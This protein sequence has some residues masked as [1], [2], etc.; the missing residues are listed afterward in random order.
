MSLVRGKCIA[1]AILCKVL[2]N[3]FGLDW[4]KYVVIDPKFFRPAEVDIVTAV[5]NAGERRSSLATEAFVR[6]NCSDDG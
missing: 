3:T 5:S 1:S 2:L 6:A 4:Q